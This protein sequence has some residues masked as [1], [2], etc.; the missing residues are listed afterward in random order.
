MKWTAGAGRWYS[1]GRGYFIAESFTAHGIMFDCWCLAA[2]PHAE[3]INGAP[4]A[5][6]EQAQAACETH[7]SATLDALPAVV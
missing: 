2:K 4:F 1:E 6:L 5:T 7:L 3:Q